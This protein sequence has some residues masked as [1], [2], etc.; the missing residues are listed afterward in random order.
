MKHS[1]LFLLA[2]TAVMP[3]A[4]SGTDNPRQSRPLADVVAD[5]RKRFDLDLK[6]PQGLLDGKTLDYADYRIRRYSAEES[7][8]NVLTPFD[9]MFEYE[10]GK[11]YRLLAYDHPR[12][13]PAEGAREMQYLAALYK[14][15]AAWEKQA[16]AL[17]PALLAALRLSPMP[18]APRTQPILTTGRSMD[19]YRVQNFAI[20]TLPGV[21][22]CGSVYIPGRAA[23]KCPLVVSPNGHFPGGRY[24]DDRQ[25]RCAMFAR[26]GAWA[27]SYDLFA[28]GESLL[29]F[30]AAAHRTPMAQTMQ[31]LNGIRIIDYFSKLPEIDP[32]R[33][34]VTGASGG[35]SQTMMLAAIDARVGVSAP[36][37]MVSAHFDGGCPCESGRPIHLAA[38]GMNNAELAAL[39]APRPQLVLSDGGDWTAGVPDVEYP[40]LRHVYGLYGKTEAVVNVHFPREGHDYGPSKRKAVYSFF[41]AH[42]GMDLAAVQNAK[43]EVDESACTVEPAEALLAFGPNGEFLPAR[44]IKGMKQLDKIFEPAD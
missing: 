31:I 16:R 42:L 33:I 40:F 11:T 29:Q 8:R 37:V 26:M 10:T 2:I 34:A 44:A 23:G 17:R 38:G 20:E 43:G 19:G 14:D 18:D 4:S 39:A 22:V 27:V 3:A 15:R 1:L 21:F 32:G 24:R 7:L 25:I 36:V 12:R 5:I 28:W 13:S 30:D 35:G 41:A 9:L 6:I